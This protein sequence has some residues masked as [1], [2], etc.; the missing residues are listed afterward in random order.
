MQPSGHLQPTHDFASGF[1]GRLLSVSC[2]LL[3]A[4]AAFCRA[5]SVPTFDLQAKNGKIIDVSAAARPVETPGAIVTPEGSIDIIA[6]PAVVI[7]YRDADPLFQSGAFTW[8]I[9][10]RFKNPTALPAGK[11][12]GLFWRW[13]AR[14]NTRSVCLQLNEGRNFL[15]GLT[16]DGTAELQVAVAVQA[17]EIT[18]DDWVTFVCRFEPG[19]RTSMQLYDSYRILLAKAENWTDIPEGFFAESDSPFT[20]GIPEELGY[21]IA[22]IQVW[23]EFIPDQKIPD[24]L[25][26]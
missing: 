5:E 25:E 10:A 22:R 13:D 3:L 20:I 12:Y 14:L 26:E 15:F 8:I 1:A 17:S 9:K 11:N 23:N 16:T 19:K 6:D 21:S 4:T 2:A 24:L 18:P 7:P